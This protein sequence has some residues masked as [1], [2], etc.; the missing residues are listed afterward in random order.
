MGFPSIDTINL[1][2][3]IV[4]REGMEKVSELLLLRSKDLRLVPSLSYLKT[5]LLSLIKD[6]LIDEANGYSAGFLTCLDM[7][8]RQLDSEDITLEDVELQLQNVLAWVDYLENEVINLQ[9][10]IDRKKIS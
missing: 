2:C 10:Q 1:F 3:D 7:F 4:R 6:E 8:R 5:V 9:C